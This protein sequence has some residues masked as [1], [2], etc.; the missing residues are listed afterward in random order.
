MIVNLFVG[1]ASGAFLDYGW[2]IPFL[3]SGPS[4]VDRA[5]RATLDRRNADVRT[6]SKPNRIRIGSAHRSVQEPAPRTPAGS[7]CVG[8]DVRVLLRRHRLLDLIC[9]G[10]GRPDSNHSAI[11]RSARGTGLRCRDSVFCCLFGS[12]R[13]THNGSRLLCP[14]HPQWAGSFPSRRYRNAARLLRRPDNSP[15]SSW[16]SRTARRVRFCRRCFR[17]STATPAPEWLMRSQVSSARHRADAGCRTRRAVWRR[18]SRSDA[19]GLRSPQPRV[20]HIPTRDTSPRHGR[21]GRSPEEPQ[22]PPP[23]SRQ[24][25]GPAHRTKGPL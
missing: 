21:P 3:A 15:S 1:E 5:L 7:G 12:N 11:P 19:R 17:P 9:D 4:G 24:P 10:D 18:I 23:Q 22:P 16:A 2:R 14:V 25:E 20:R 6:T 13:S 8:D